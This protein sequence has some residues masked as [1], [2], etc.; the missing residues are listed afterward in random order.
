MWKEEVVFFCLPSSNSSRRI[1]QNNEK[2]EIRKGHLQ[3]PKHT[4]YSLDQFALR[5][6]LEISLSFSLRLRNA[7]FK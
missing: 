3:M 2:Y 7:L 6:C 1:G 5:K 4:E